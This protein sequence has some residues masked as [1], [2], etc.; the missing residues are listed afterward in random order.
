MENY[1]VTQSG[2][3]TVIASAISL[4]ASHA[5]LSSSENV[6]ILLTALVVLFSGAVSFYGRYRKGDLTFSGF[7]KA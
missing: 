2:N 5:D 6:Q 4:I 3:L 7:R 1:S